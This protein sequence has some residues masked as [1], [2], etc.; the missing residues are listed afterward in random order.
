MKRLLILPLA[1]RAYLSIAGIVSLQASA[2][3]DTA[4]N[5]GIRREVEAESIP[6]VGE[7][8]L[9]DNS[10][11]SENY[12]LVGSQKELEELWTDVINADKPYS[13]R[14]GLNVSEPPEVDF[15]KYSVI[16]FSGVGPEETAVDSVSV[17]VYDSDMTVVVSIVATD[18]GST[19]RLSLWK[20]PVTGYRA[21]FNILHEKADSGQ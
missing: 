9:K 2:A 11:R 3:N 1:L 15:D 4:E 17:A 10:G 14:L 13:S 21:V 20:V 18:S 6:V 7:L 8:K 16:W 5:T 19:G 12:G